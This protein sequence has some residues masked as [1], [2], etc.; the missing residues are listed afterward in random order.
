M[1]TDFGFA[2]LALAS[3]LKHNRS[4][5]LMEK[6]KELREKHNTPEGMLDKNGKTEKVLPG[7][8]VRLELHER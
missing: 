5:K 7:F 2:D 4:L 1:D 3:S 6:L 8:R